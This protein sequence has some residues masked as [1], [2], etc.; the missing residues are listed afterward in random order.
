MSIFLQ[1]HNRM[2]KLNPL[3]VKKA[4]IF[5]REKKIKPIDG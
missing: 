5:L 2:T 1:D 3:V 4:Y